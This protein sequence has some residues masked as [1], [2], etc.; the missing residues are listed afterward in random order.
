MFFAGVQTSSVAT[1]NLIFA[2]CKLPEYQDKILDELDSVIVQPHLRELMKTG[3]L[4]KDAK[5]ADLDIL[6]LINYEN[7]GDMQFYSNCFNE[8]MRM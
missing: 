3:K 6:S 2:L 1:Q 7:N 5:I 8:S 4:A